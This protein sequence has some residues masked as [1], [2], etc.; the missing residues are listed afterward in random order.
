MFA[1]CSKCDA[2]LWAE[3]TALAHVA[4]VPCRS[5]GQVHYLGD[6][7]A[8]G[9]TARE[10]RDQVAALAG[11]QMLEPAAAYS[12]LLGIMSIERAREVGQ[13]AKA[14]VSRDSECR[15]QPSSSVRLG[16]V[17]AVCLVL[18]LL[19][20]GYFVLSW[21]QAIDQVAAAQAPAPAQPVALPPTVD[22]PG[23]ESV[24]RTTP[25]TALLTDDSGRL[26]KVTASTPREVLRKFCQE[27]GSNCEPIEL[28][29]T[30]AEQSGM[31]L[32]VFRDFH[33]LGRT[34]A[35]TIHR[36]TRSRRWTSGDGI[37]PLKAAPIDPAHLGSRRIA[38]TPG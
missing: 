32:G 20:T 8:L 3:P 17:A 22:A 37:H 6:L 34:Y 31:W 19:V 13:K 21:Q 7:E 30:R 4:S 23:L 15:E 24:S 18:T 14:A 38:L 2:K 27:S 9:A 28:A 11:R 26:T 25:G 36:D 35:L 33:D 12:V 5:C 29:S 1:I 10:Q 16:A